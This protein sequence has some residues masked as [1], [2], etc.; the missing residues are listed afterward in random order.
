MTLTREEAERRN[1][2]CKKRYYEKNKELI[3][4]KAK[5]ARESNPDYNATRREK[6]KEKLQELIDEGVY[7]PAKRGRKA[8]Y[9]THEEALEAKRE[10]MRVCRAQ[11]AERIAHAEN[12]LLQKKM[13]NPEI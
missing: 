12:L 8:L 7:Q 1:R 9:H 5:T 3:L 10:Q 2:E 11:R 13:M 4:G 6:Y